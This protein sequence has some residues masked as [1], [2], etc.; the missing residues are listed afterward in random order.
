[1]ISKDL[2]DEIYLNATPSLYTIDLTKITEKDQ[3]VLLK[4]FEEPNKFTYI[5]LYGESLYNVLETIVNRSYILKMASYTREQLEPL[6][7]GENKEVILK[8]C[9]TPGQIEIANHTDM[10]ALD[11]LCNTILSRMKVAPYENAL[12]IANKINFKDEY[13]KFDLSL[14]IKALGLKMLDNMNK[15]VFKQY[16]LLIEMNKKIWFMNNKKKYFENFITKLW[17][18]TR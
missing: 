13:S 3:N 6:V 10:N 16:E 1:M 8:L 12:T 11:I 17:E 18:A 2:V 7:M 9:S 5:I 4:L 14:F 15:D